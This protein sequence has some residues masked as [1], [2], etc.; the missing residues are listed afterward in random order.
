[1]F[2]IEVQGQWWQLVT[3]V[4]GMMIEVSFRVRVGTKMIG[5]NGEARYWTSNLLLQ[6]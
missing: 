6:E 2:E 1:M 5:K 3:T 4:M